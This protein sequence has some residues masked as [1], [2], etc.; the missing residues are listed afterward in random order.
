M[1]NLK[2]NAPWITYLYQLKKL[3][4]RDTEVSVKFDEDEYK[5]T[6]CVDN[7]Y[8]ADALSKILPSERDFGNVHTTLEVV[9]SNKEIC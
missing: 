7:S 6:I 1:S 5:Y 2:L 4:E 3:F 9:P 8:K